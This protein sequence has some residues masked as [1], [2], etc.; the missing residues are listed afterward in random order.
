MLITNGI[1]SRNI[2]DKQFEEYKR[3]GYR[4]IDIPAEPETPVEPETPKRKR[5]AKAGD[6]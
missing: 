2:A 4:A 3:R 5:A 1:V 6:N